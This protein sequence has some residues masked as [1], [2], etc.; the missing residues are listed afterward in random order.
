MVDL[1]TLW[2]RREP[3]GQEKFHQGGFQQ[4]Q[5]SVLGNFRHVGARFG[6]FQPNH[7][8]PEYKRKSTN[9]Q[10]TGLTTKKL[11]RCTNDKFCLMT[12]LPIGRQRVEEN[13]IK[14]HACIKHSMLMFTSIWLNKKIYFMGWI[15]LWN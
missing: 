2:N 12:A 7:T 10:Q 8:Q 13:R 1:G 11:N 3:P 9:G 6:H 4:F 14:V 5:Y 15:E